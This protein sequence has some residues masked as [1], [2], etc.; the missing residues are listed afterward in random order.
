MSIEEIYQA[1]I[2]PMKYDT[3]RYLGYPGLGQKADTDGQMADG[4]MADGRMAGGRMVDTRTDGGRTEGWTDGRTN[5]M[6]SR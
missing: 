2:L 6:F 5:N 1:H 3:S 4:R